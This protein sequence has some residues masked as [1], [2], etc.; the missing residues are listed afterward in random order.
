MFMGNQHDAKGHT[1][2]SE[3]GFGENK[4]SA[5]LSKSERMS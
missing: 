2:I 4:T 5:L 3:V 1:S